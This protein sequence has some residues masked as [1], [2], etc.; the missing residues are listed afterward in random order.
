MKYFTCPTQYRAKAYGC[1]RGPWNATQAFLDMGSRCPCGKGLKPYRPARLTV[2]KGSAG[3][4]S[5]ESFTGSAYCAEPAVEAGP[6]GL[7]CSRHAYLAH[8]S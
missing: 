6:A 7:Y 2:P 1:G 8:S 3:R 5:A 4:C